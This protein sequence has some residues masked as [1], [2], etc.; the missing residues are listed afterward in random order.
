MKPAFLRSFTPGATKYHN[1]KVE[2]DGITFDSAKESRVYQELKILAQ[3]GE[4][5]GFERQKV[6]ELVPSQY[7]GKKCV[8]KAVTYKAD[9]VVYHQDGSIAVIDA[10]GMRDAKYIIKRKLMRWIHKI[11]VCEV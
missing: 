1:R 8:E 11:Q 3:S 10:K 6:F 5:K 9:F 7:E 2:I 4:I